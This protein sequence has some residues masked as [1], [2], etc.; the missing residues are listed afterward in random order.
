MAT[1]ARKLILSNLQTTFES[2]TVANGYKTTVVKVQ[3][4]ARGYADV[5]TG[6]RPFI[7]YVPQAEQVEY[8]PF[9][10]I[11]CTL[12]VSV[13]GHVSGNSQSDRSTKLNDLIDDLIAALNADPTR[14][15]N[16]INTKLVQFETDEGDPDARGDGSVLAQVQIQYER[17]VSSS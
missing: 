12:N 14:G 8:Q 5:K 2:I 7:G 13:I 9:N 17:S 16:A 3:A 11:R 15:T 10:R 6:E 4:L 1:P